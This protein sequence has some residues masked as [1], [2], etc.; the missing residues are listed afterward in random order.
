MKKIILV[1]L[2]T[3]ITSTLSG[4]KLIDLYKGGPV[5]LIPDTEYALGND[6]NQVFRT[7]YDTI[8]KK[9][10]GNRKSLIMM[11][12]GSVVVNHAYR[13]FYTKFS[14]LGVFI[15]EFGITNSKGKQFKKTKSIAGILNNEVMFSELDNMGNMICA[16][17]DG[18]YIKTIKLNYGVSQ[19]VPLDNNKIAVVGWVI[20]SDKFRDF[21]AI[22]DYETNEERIIW[23]YYT[24]RCPESSKCELFY[25]S[26]TFKEKGIY[27]FISMPYSKI[28]GISSPPKIASLGD[29]LLV[30]IPTTGEISV[31]NLD[32]NLVSKNKI[33][34][35]KNYISLEEQREIQQRAIDKVRKN[36]ATLSNWVG[37]EESKL[38]QQAFIS[39]MEADLKKISKPIP[40]P[41]FSTIMKD[42]DENVLFFE[43][44]KEENANKF[45]V[46]V[47]GSSGKFVSQSSF[48]CDEYDLQINPSKM[49]FF[50]GYLYALQLKKNA[51]G[52]PLRLVRFK[53]SN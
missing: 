33:E 11:P 38:A 53:L 48:A 9:P 3:I 27:S 17:L 25:Y 41:Y 44:P 49:V 37:E 36:E 46:W 23:D 45:N 51:R 52:I 7:Y 21:V 26:Y 4:Q 5:K 24:D 42:S 39:E 30:A 50:N 13:N 40:I 31:Y 1:S 28:T 2:I 34:W 10:M 12:N 43:F 8:Y 16:D 20:W 29:K 15:E 32:G 18:N 19:M 14:P 35:S 6:W 22:V 47:Y